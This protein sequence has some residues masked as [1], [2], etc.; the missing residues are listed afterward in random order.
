MDKINEKN[1]IEKLKR[2]QALSES[3]TFKGEKN[4]AEEAIRKIKEKLEHERTKEFPIEYQFSLPDT[5]S[6][7]LFVA[8]LRKYEIKPYRYP[9]QRSTTVMAKISKT[10]LDNTLWPEYEKLND[11]LRTYLEEITE[12]V[13]IESVNPDTSESDVIKSLN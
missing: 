13:I 9:R 7:K 10:F 5:W 12:K 11:A 6:R 3:T 8:L 4:A 1:I 2:I